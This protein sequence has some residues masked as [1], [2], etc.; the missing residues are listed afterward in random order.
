[1]GQLRSLLRGIAIGTGAGPADVLCDLDRSMA[2]LRLSTLA[3][4]AVA[5]LEQMPAEVAAGTTRLRWSNAGHPPPVVL[6]PD[7]AVTV[8]AEDRP[9]MLLGVDPH[10]PRR[11]SVAVL[12]RGCTVLLYSDGL[13]E[14]RDSDLDAG[15]D[16]LVEVLTEL[17]DRPLPEL[18]DLLVERMVDHHPD[19]DVALVAVR[20]HPQD[21]PRPD[22]P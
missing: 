14:R 21:R 22:R 5:R 4:A 9:D 11:E 8:L 15:H 17:A 2:V 12:E 6:G 19:D 1:M 16:R 18:C 10:R 20:L 3:T 13:V 7:G